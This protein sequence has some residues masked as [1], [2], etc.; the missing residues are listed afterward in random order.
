MSIFVFFSIYD[1][2]P[3]YLKQRMESF[4]SNAYKG[5]TL[6]SSYKTQPLTTTETSTDFNRTVQGVA[7]PFFLV[8]PGAPSDREKI[9]YANSVYDNV[10]NYLYAT[11]ASEA[12]IWS[13]F[14]S[15]SLHRHIFDRLESAGLVDRSRFVC[16]PVEGAGEMTAF[17]YSGGVTPQHLVFPVGAKEINWLTVMRGAVR[18]GKVLSRS[19]HLAIPEGRLGALEMRRLRLW[20]S[21]DWIAECCRRGGMTRYEPF[22]VGCAMYD[23]EATSMNPKIRH[24]RSMLYLGDH[25]SADTLILSDIANG[26][27]TSDFWMTVDAIANYHENTSV[28]SLFVTEADTWQDALV[29]NT[30]YNNHRG[31]EFLKKRSVEDAISDYSR[32]G[33][34]R[35]SRIKNF[36][37]SVLSAEQRETIYNAF[38]PSA[39]SE[40]SASAFVDAC[41][42]S[43]CRSG[44]YVMLHSLLKLINFD[45]L[46][47]IGYEAHR[48]LVFKIFVPAL[49]AVFVSNGGL[50]DAFSNGALTLKLLGEKAGGATIGNMLERSAMTVNRDRQTRN[51]AMNDT[52]TLYGAMSDMTALPLAVNIGVKIEENEK[53]KELLNIINDNL[54]KMGMAKERL[55]AAQRK[56]RR[57]LKRRKA[58]EEEKEDGEEEAENGPNREEVVEENSKKRTKRQVKLMRAEEDLYSEEDELQE[59]YDDLPDDYYDECDG[60][61]SSSR[62]R[63]RNEGSGRQYLLSGKVQDKKLLPPGICVSTISNENREVNVVDIQK[64]LTARQANNNNNC[65]RILLDCKEGRSS[66]RSTEGISAT[67]YL[68]FLMNIFDKVFGLK[69]GSILNSI[70]TNVS[71]EGNGV[72]NPGK[73]ISSRQALE[74]DSILTENNEGAVHIG[75]GS[76]REIRMDLNNPEHVK[77]R[78]A[79]LI[80]DPPSLVGITDR[81]TIER[82]LQNEQMLS[83]L[84]SNPIF[85]SIVNAEY[86]DVGRY[87]VLSNI[88][89][90]LSVTLTCLVDGD[91]PLLQDTRKNVKQIL[92]KG[93]TRTS[94]NRSGC[95]SNDYRS[96]GQ[97]PSDASGLRQRLLPE[98]IY[99]L[100]SI[101]V[102]RG[103]GGRVTMKKQTCKHMF[104]KML[105]FLFYSLDPWSPA[106][107][108]LA[109]F[110]VDPASRATLFKAYECRN[111]TDLWEQLVRHVIEGD[112]SWLT[113]YEYTPLSNED[114]EYYAPID[115]FTVLKMAM[116]DEGIVLPP[117]LRT[118]E[119]YDQRG[120][121]RTADDLYRESMIIKSEA[122]RPTL[123]NPVA[124]E[125][126]NV[127]P[128]R[129]NPSQIILLQPQQEEAAPEILLNSL[130]DQF[131]DSV[132][133]DWVK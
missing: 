39:K 89:K 22:S 94:K 67:F 21:F 70:H 7:S 119:E 126:I 24:E 26:G 66:T 108:R 120:V 99:G 1:K 132:S 19:R 64:L 15:P 86:G 47:L 25:F 73:T 52:A 80:L 40:G 83:S 102:V 45:I 121:P 65:Q 37:M 104:C 46:N 107:D 122:F 59:E 6:M 58:D 28:R 8:S 35:K 50:G 53:E 127:V 31:T 109:N 71:C 16:N 55:A 106:N 110:F 111:S 77:A 13:P 60:V 84:S 5:A 91:M 133:S 23:T 69:M 30:R 118:N 72:F 10:L 81:T 29:H 14:N 11:V 3:S 34:N 82:V 20:R 87:V 38:G 85:T 123:F 131:V 75:D 9:V 124:Q 44:V 17:R 129:Q 48:T 78:F 57:I 61:E 115:F 56:A 12:P 4:L 96:A 130:L 128:M 33:E 18:L 100:K 32:F 125:E 98:C 93:R 63:K 116:L 112:T 76:C 114:N 113:P 2:P 51:Y 36:A 92:E 68:R 54:I 95:E 62:K 49:L 41:V 43:P 74:N 27:R 103:R 90:Y 117:E 42:V 105:K 88:V 79:E 97:Y 101:A